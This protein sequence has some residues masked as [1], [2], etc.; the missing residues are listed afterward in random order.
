V[1][2]QC[3]PGTQVDGVPSMDVE[4]YRD[5]R[6][7]EAQD[8]GAPV[9]VLTVTFAGTS[10]L[11]VIRVGSCSD[12]ESA[13]LCF[14]LRPLTSTV[15]MGPPGCGPAYYNRVISWQQVERTADWRRSGWVH[16]IRN[17][18]ADGSAWTRRCAEAR[19][20]SLLPSSALW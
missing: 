4:L 16:A 15:P 12:A 11:P 7:A 6:C 19:R 5:P 10:P 20:L 13:Q 3:V 1:V 17:F 2:E 14:V 9:L 8:P 18:G